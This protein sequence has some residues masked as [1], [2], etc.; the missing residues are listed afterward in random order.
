MKDEQSS[1]I[2]VF[3]DNGKLAL[4]LRA[5]SD[6]SYPLHWDFS[7]AGGINKGEDPQT[8]AIRELKEELGVEGV[9]KYVGEELYQDQFGKDQLYIFK[10]KYEGK[11]NLNPKE[12]EKVQFFGLEEIGDMIKSEIKFHPEFIFLWNK[13][14]ITT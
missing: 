8:A 5:K 11:F 3:D 13:G 12:V 6:K 9:L 1:V 7:A 10:T 4:Q 2:L 14:V